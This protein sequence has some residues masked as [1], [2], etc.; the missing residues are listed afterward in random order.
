MYLKKQNMIL[1]FVNNKKQKTLC[2]ASYI[3]LAFQ[4][5]TFNDAFVISLKF[6][7]IFHKIKTV[8]ISLEYLVLFCFFKKRRILFITITTNYSTIAFKK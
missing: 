2:I 6:L 7:I 1:K 5:Y 3:K 8:F 4:I